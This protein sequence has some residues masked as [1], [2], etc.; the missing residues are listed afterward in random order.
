MDP[1]ADILGAMAA[2]RVPLLSTTRDVES[3]I[4]R[5]SSSKTSFSLAHYR[6][7]TGI[8]GSS[9]VTT[10]ADLLRGV[11]I[12]AGRELPDLS[13]EPQG[14]QL[15]PP[16]HERYGQTNLIF[17]TSRLQ[18]ARHLEEAK[19]FDEPVWLSLGPE[20]RLRVVRERDVMSACLSVAQQLFPLLSPKLRND[21][22][23]LLDAIRWLDGPWARYYPFIAA[24]G[25]RSLLEGMGV[26]GH[27]EFVSPYLVFMMCATLRIRQ[28]N[29]IPVIMEVIRERESKQRYGITFSDKPGGVEPA[30]FPPGGEPPELIRNQIRT[31]IGIPYVEAICQYAMAMIRTVFEGREVG[32][33]H[34]RAYV[35]NALPQ[36]DP[37]R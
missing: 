28:K 14:K 18:K 4:S 30:I 17:V 9:W 16:L 13:V 33:Q 29:P 26:R 6:V 7:L 27:P 3:V 5:L 11:D 15:L 12:S 24:T 25:S 37:L 20:E 10:P 2:E 34:Y 36:P 8:I 22:H 1:I 23:P 32:H 35:T 21:V 19:T 31:C